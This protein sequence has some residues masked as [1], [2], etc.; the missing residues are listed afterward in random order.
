MEL[1]HLETLYNF[2]EQATYVIIVE[3][4]V[5]PSLMKSMNNLTVS[6]TVSKN[7]TI[8]ILQGKMED[9]EALYGAMNVLF[10]HRFT[11]LNITK[12]D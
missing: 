7:K 5:D 10:N 3:G 11:V 6:H 9:Q 12:L 2:S 4:K 8:S 1:E